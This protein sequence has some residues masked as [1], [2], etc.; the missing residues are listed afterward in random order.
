MAISLG[1][2]EIPK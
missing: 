2:T 1:L